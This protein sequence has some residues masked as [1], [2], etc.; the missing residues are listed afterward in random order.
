MIASRIPMVLIL[1]VF[2]AGCA[3]EGPQ[4]RVEKEDGTVIIGQVVEGDGDAIVIESAQGR[5]TIAQ[6][7]ISSITYG[8]VAEMDEGGSVPGDGGEA[9]TEQEE[10]EETFRE[11]TVP[12]GTS[13]ALV[14]ESGLSSKTSSVEDTARARLAEAVTVD[15]VIVLPEGA[16]FVG[17]VIEA[18]A[19]GKVEGRA[20][21]GVRFHEVELAD[22]GRHDVRTAA[23]RREAAGTKARDA[24]NIGVGAA[25][26]ALIGGIVGGGK[27][28]GV[29]TAVGAGAGTGVVMATA[30]DEVSMAAGSTVRTTLEAPLTVLVP[31]PTEP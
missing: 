7:E 11:V 27:G 18:E 4:A 22:G 3:S 30:G 1:G 21:L 20:R 13:L 17:S 28:A 5:T 25:A 16:T 8:G 31:D 14:L 19:S 6:S 2:A 26:G 23:V 15:G 10:P 29:G 12:E 24:R 9:E